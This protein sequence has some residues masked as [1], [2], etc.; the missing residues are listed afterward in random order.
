MFIPSKAS[1]TLFGVAQEVD[2]DRAAAELLAYGYTVVGSQL[3]PL[4]RVVFPQFQELLR[5]P[6]HGLWEVSDP[7]EVIAGTPDLGLLK[8]RD[9][10]PRPILRPDQI[11]EGRSHYDAKKETLHFNGRLL[12]YLTAQR[13]PVEPYQPMLQALESVHTAAY[14]LCAELAARLDEQLPGF[15]FAERT[16]KAE[17]EAKTRVVCYSPHI[18][19]S[20]AG[21]VHRDRCLLSVHIQS[22]HRGLRLW[23]RQGRIASLDET[24]ESSIVVFMGTKFFPLTRGRLS[25]LPHGV[26]LS[27]EWK[28]A[29]R[30]TMV[31][32]IHGEVA[33]EEKAW[34]DQNADQLAFDPRIH[35]LT[36]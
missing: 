14:A 4:A 18:G 21:A 6:A 32:F 22:T 29:S 15:R 36:A 13:A 26:V 28:S 2:F 35:K 17:G 11:A 31:S 1:A 20:D 8:A 34:G 9:G 10:R 24:D 25:G 27:P 30:L 12:P 16:E 5:D 23:D 33:P 19:R 3:P 7:R